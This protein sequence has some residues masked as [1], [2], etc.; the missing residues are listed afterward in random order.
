M[1]PNPDFTK[2]TESHGNTSNVS[3]EV[4]LSQPHAT[5]AKTDLPHQTHLGVK[6][7]RAS[8]RPRRHNLCAPSHPKK[9]TAW[10]PKALV[11]PC[12]IHVQCGRTLSTFAHSCQY[13]VVQSRG[14]VDGC[15]LGTA[16]PGVD[17]LSVCMRR[18][19]G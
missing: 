19:H 14:A 4:L 13:L 17:T 11:S 15:A 8:L 18:T 2:F 6:G 5:K 1:P 9:D 3:K 10:S 16:A 12:S 7:R